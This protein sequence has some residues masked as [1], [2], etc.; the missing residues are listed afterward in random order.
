VYKTYF[1]HFIL[2]KQTN[3]LIVHSRGFLSGS[4]ITIIWCLAECYSLQGVESLVH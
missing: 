4:C 1:Y 2:V 3:A